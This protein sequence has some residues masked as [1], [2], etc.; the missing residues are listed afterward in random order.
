MLEPRRL[1]A[2]ACAERMAQSLGE[3]VGCTVGYRMRFDSPVSSP[4]RIEVVTEGG[5]T[6]LL[7]GDP[8]LQGVAALIFDEVHERSHQADLGHAHSLHAREHL[9]PPPRL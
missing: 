2:R 5:L 1:A 6:R 8:A 9:A 3:S 4:T 7:Q